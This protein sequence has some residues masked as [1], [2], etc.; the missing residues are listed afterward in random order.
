MSIASFAPCRSNSFGTSRSMWSG[1]GLFAPSLASWSLP[2]FPCDPL[3]PLIH[4][5]EVTAMHCLSMYAVFLKKGAFFIPIQPASSQL[6]KCFVRPLMM[7]M[8]SDM[9]LRGMNLGTALTALRTATISPIWFDWCSPGIHMAMFLSWFG[10]N[11]TPQLLCA[12]SCLLLKHAPFINT[13]TSAAR[14]VMPRV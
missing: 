3:C 1:C 13:M 12:F 6:L 4:W 9:I 8:E 14:R 10:P 7:Y 11:H 2:S 5:K